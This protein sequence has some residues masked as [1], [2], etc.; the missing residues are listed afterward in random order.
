MSAERSWDELV[1]LNERQEYGQAWLPDREPDHPRTLV[2]TVRAYDQG[3]TSE[4]TGQ[5]PWIC[6]VE[7]CDG[8]L[9]SIWRTGRC[10]FRSSRSSARCR[11][12][13]SSSATAGSRRRRA[14]RAPRRRTL[15]SITVDREQ[16]LPA[17]LARPQLE[18]PAD[19]GPE[20]APVM[21]DGFAYGEQ[22]PEPIDVPDADVLD[23]KGDDD[24]VP[25]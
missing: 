17:F 14:A 10:W 6:T 9:W 1:E 18:P 16:Q 7:A 15:Y 5:Q 4:Y 25:Y 12:S 23:E 3:P 21:A 22:R 19:P 8:K 2:G 20:P 11:T 24:D 13:G